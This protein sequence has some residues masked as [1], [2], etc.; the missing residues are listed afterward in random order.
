MFVRLS[1]RLKKDFTLMT[2][3][4]IPISVAINLIGGRINSL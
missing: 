2:I 4:L 1:N 3:L